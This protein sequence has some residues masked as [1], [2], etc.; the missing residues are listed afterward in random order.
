MGD[1]AR[2]QGMQLGTEP[3]TLKWACVNCDGEPWGIG[4]WEDRG[5]YPDDEW[6][7]AAIKWAQTHEVPRSVGQYPPRGSI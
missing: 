2:P 4:V 5:G 7:A 6:T 1:E 3:A